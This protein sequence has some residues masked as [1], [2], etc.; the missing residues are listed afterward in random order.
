MTKITLHLD[1]RNLQGRKV[2]QLRRQGIVPANI[3]GKK[4]DSSSVQVKEKDFQKTFE[5]AGETS[6]IYATV[7]DE[8]KERPLLVSATQIHPVTGS[9]LHVDFHQVDLTEKVTAAVP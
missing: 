5:A 8:K 4:I 9:V 2:K 6:I 1:T 3:F 7:G